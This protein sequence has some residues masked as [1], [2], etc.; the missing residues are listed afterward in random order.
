[1]P[2]PT[3][4]K[5]DPKV[6]TL[7]I[8]EDK[9]FSFFSKNEFFNLDRLFGYAS[10]HRNVSVIVTGQIF[11]NCPKSIRDMSNFYIIWR[12]DDLDS[13]KT[14]GRRVGLKKEE[15]IF[16]LSLVAISV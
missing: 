1:M 7:V 16:T 14:I 12:V 13:I 15:I 8:I 6:K 9:S 3:S 11:M 10:T 4:D 2:P 5:F